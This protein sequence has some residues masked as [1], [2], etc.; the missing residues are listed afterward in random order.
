MLKEKE[1]GEHEKFFV[2]YVHKVIKKGIFC[3]IFPVSIKKS[4]KNAAD[5]EHYQQKNKN[6]TKPPKGVEQ[7]NW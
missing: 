2:F 7:W 5:P 1:R 3:R 4:S 6:W